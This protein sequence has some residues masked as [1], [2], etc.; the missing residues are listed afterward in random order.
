[1]KSNEYL[2]R[3]CYSELVAIILAGLLH[4]LTE[5]RFSESIAL[6]YSAGISIACVGYLIWRGMR[7]AGVLRVWGMRCDNFWLAL[8]AQLVFVVAGAIVLV[9]IG[10]TF[11]SLALPRTFWI[12]L[13]LYPIWGTA[14][15]FALQNLIAR[16]LTSV[17][18]SP[19]AVA[20][21][22]STL[23]GVSHYPRLD[24]MLL[25][26]VAGVFF[27]LIYRKFPNLWAVGIAHGVLGSLAVY[28][29]L[30]EDP[31]A[32]LLSYISGR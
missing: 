28:F 1:M 26:L 21:A 6:A 5:I 4:V 22:A 12:T 14:Q 13:A 7:T 15:Q 30:K 17:L 29:I 16:N 25:T 2:N 20:V 23:F 10:V 9:G 19:L 11:R 31:G 32:A 24:L 3:P 27:T 8:R 18:S